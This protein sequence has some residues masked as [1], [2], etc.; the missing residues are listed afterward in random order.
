MSRF[1]LKAKLIEEPTKGIHEG[2]IPGHFVTRGASTTFQLNLLNRTFE[3]EQ[4]KQ[5][6]FAFKQDDE[7]VHYN[8]YDEN[9]VQNPKFVHQVQKINETFKVVDMLF[10]N[11]DENDTLWFDKTS[12]AN[13]VEFEIVIKISGING[14]DPNSI[15][16][17]IETQPLVA[18]ND[19]IYGQILGE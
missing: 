15:H 10:L 8:L 7:C 18:V 4:L 11:L 3:F 9:G 12:N 19:S 17:F 2:K 13:F 6:T 1:E 14:N 16:T 5:V